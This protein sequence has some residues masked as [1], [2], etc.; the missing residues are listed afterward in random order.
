M[1]PQAGGSGFQF[2]F[3]GFRRASNI[4]SKP[5]RC[6]RKHFNIRVVDLPS[7]KQIR[8]TYHYPSWTGLQNVTE[9][10]GGDLRAVEGT[11]AELE[12]ATDRPLRDG[13][14]VLDDDQ[15]IHAHRRRGQRLQGHRAHGQGRRYHVAALDQGQPV[16][17]SDDYFI[18][19]RKAE[20][21]RRDHRAPG[22]DY[23]A[24][25]IEE[26]TV[27]VKADDEFGSQTIDAAL[28]GQRRPR[29]DRRS[30]EAEG[31]EAGRRLHRAVARGFQGW[32][33]A[34]S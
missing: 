5:A 31:R 3:A 23:R 1:Q 13:L 20:P 15:Q 25:P 18:E 29:A 11:E 12:I 22:R 30:A 34:T 33:R 16:R 17:L 26:V 4:T 24:S 2:L 6:T 9:E 10:H 28:L 7:V 21:P 8:V 27:A 14:L 32:C 19:A